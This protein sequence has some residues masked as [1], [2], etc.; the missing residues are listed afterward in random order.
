[1]CARCHDHKYDPIPTADYYSLYSIFLNSTER[2]TPIAEPPAKDGAY[3]AFEKELLRRQQQ[4]AQALLKERNASAERTRHHLIDYLVAQT[5]L[6]KYPEE[7]FDQQLLATDT[8]P[9]LVRRWEAWLAQDARLT[10]PVFLP[11][12]R[13]AALKADEF[14]AGAPAILEQLAQAGPTVN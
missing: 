13:L 14:A 9:N 4:F 11:W 3:P 10:D 8:I 7:G 5:E 2:L 1:A 6:S 12:R